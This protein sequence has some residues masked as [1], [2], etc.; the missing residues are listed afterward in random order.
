MLLELCLSV[1]PPTVARPA[2]LPLSLQL[3]GQSLVCG[4]GCWL[5]E[6]V[7][8]PAP[9]SLQNLICYWLLSRSLPQLFIWEHLW[10]SDVVDA[11]ETGVEE[12]LDFL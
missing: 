3:P 8:D 12:C 5:P 6:G 4:A 10:P 1:L 9:L 7:S 2:S 11:L